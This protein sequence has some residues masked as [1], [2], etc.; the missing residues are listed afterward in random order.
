MGVSAFDIIAGFA[1]QNNE[2]RAARI[3]E[4]GEELRE[5]R[6]LYQ[7]IAMNKFA[8]DESIYRDHQ[9]KWLER[10]SA[11]RSIGDSATKDDIAKEMARLDGRLKGTETD[12]QREN[13]LSD[14]YQNIEA[15]YEKDSEGKDVLDENGLQ[16]VSKWKYT[17]NH[18][19]IAPEW[20]KKYY[21]PEMFFTAKEQIESGTKGMWTRFIRGEEF[22]TGDQ[23]LAKLQTDLDEGAQRNANDWN[24]YFKTSP[25]EFIAKADD[26]IE[27]TAGIGDEWLQLFSSIPVSEE[28]RKNSNFLISQS[29]INST[30][31]NK[32]S[33]TEKDSLVLD[34]IK[35]IPKGE[36]MFVSS[37][38]DGVLQLKGST[39]VTKAQISDAYSKYVES[40]TLKAM[41]TI[42]IGPDGK[43]KQGDPRQIEDIKNN[44]ASVIGKWFNDN[45]VTV[46]SDA[47]FGESGS[48]IYL[49]PNSVGGHYDVNL[50][51]QI[52]G[53]LKNLVQQSPDTVYEMF[54]KA[55]IDLPNAKRLES[56]SN[57]ATWKP[58]LDA[59][60][61]A[62]LTHQNKTVSTELP[63]NLTN[64][65][66]KEWGVPELA[67]ISMTSAVTS[68]DTMTADNTGILVINPDTK[69]MEF[70]SWSQIHAMYS[71]TDTMDD[72][73][74]AKTDL[75]NLLYGGE[76]KVNESLKTIYPLVVDKFKLN[77]AISNNNDD[78]NDGNDD[79]SNIVSS[80]PKFQSTEG[81]NYT[82]TIDGK[83]QTFDKKETIPVLNS[84]SGT[85]EV[86]GYNSNSGTLSTRGKLDT[87][88]ELESANL[89]NLAFV[90]SFNTKGIYPDGKKENP[91]IIY[92]DKIGYQVNTGFGKNKKLG[93]TFTIEGNTYV[94]DAVSIGKDN[95]GSSKY[96]VQL[97]PQSKQ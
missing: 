36:E 34:I 65:I 42:T 87:I 61:N 32:M 46:Q 84:T 13:I 72:P 60:S 10:D 52:A 92:S 56:T 39:G 14:Y 89:L 3:K 62:K 15:I 58:Y 90:E 57:F 68:S 81:N 85:Y 29:S 73:I 9:K 95:I 6:L 12:E 8:T 43:L 71:K 21:D 20:G 35:T 5:Q 11:L 97:V 26:T 18:T 94:L 22:D 74:A 54:E 30:L 64:D 23:V 16:K 76:N 96:K 51:Q 91:I 63:A 86:Y 48:G 55:G 47:L 53:E 45:K 50:T 38:V 49:I 77:E 24:N 31:F 1:E 59:W 2:D 79:T 4:R 66:A 40:Q 25:K 17:G 27:T 41:Q 70:N 67:G 83:N 75:E 44:Y 93:D 69:V 80:I 33:A 88:N 82:V 7:Q 78:N 28:E 37:Y 19:P